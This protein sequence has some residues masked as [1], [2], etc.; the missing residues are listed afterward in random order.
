MAYKREYIIKVKIANRWLYIW[1]WKLYDGGFLNCTDP[2]Q[3][4]SF[5][6]VLEAEA[7][8][9]ARC[10]PSQLAGIEYEIV[11]SYHEPIPTPDNN[12][13]RRF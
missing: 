9:K 13:S 5:P 12:N 1:D 11:D 6:S 2:T 3:A 8:M 4:L 7:H 10:T